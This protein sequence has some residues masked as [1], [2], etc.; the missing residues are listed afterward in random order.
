MLAGHEVGV[1]APRPT[2]TGALASP[3]QTSRSGVPGSAHLLAFGARVR[4]AEVRGADRQ[5]WASVPE[6]QAV[7]TRAFEPAVVSAGKIHRE[8][9][10]PTQGLKTGVVEPSDCTHVARYGP[11]R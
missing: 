8:I 11:D 6:I 5:V 2:P 10:M 3:C 9:D 7:E 1:V 4:C